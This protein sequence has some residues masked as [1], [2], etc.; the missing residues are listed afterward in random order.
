MT[1]A[2]LMGLNAEDFK[3]KMKEGFSDKAFLRLFKR[4]EIPELTRIVGSLKVEASLYQ[5]PAKPNRLNFN[6]S[7]KAYYKILKSV[8]PTANSPVKII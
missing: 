5:D 1:I 4:I 7:S 3:T 2:T 8:F 6:D